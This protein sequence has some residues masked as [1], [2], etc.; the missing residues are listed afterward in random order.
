MTAGCVQASDGSGPSAGGDVDLIVPAEAGDPT[1][2]VA[3]A[4][5]PCLADRLRVDV[6]VR[7]LPGD[8]GVLG[9]QALVDADRDGHTL[10]IS[11]VS[12]TV[13]T[14]LLL[15]ERTYRVEDF[16]FLGVVRS[17]PVV[18][19]TAAD[20]PVDSAESL[21]AA[22]QAGSP[23]VTVANR[24]D[25]TVEGYTLWLLNFLA[26]TRLESAPVDSDA[27][28]LR[29]VVA[30]DYAAGLVTLTPELLSGIRAGEVRLLAS[31]GLQQPTYLPEVPTIYEAV[32][33][34]SFDAMPDL[35]IDTAFSAPDYVGDAKYTELS[36]ALSR[37]LSTD[38]VQRD[39]GAEFVPADQIGA[40][41]QR[42]RYW[43]L[44]RSVRLGL[45]MAEIEGR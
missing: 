4:V 43:K 5:A 28:I 45:N 21:L 3:R 33:Y 35:V 36:S 32:G 16:S 23:P 15:P 27:E 38:N 11:S 18:L 40:G 12:P 41:E 14:P 26:E 7:N 10:M 31:G 17:A 25:K 44:Q 19:F 29:G 8:N 2:T 1:D 9:N 13:V 39:I 42:A 34:R 20:S 30:G 37:C 6:V 24:G 22:A